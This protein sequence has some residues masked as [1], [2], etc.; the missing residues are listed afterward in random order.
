LSYI[1]TNADATA[2]ANDVV[3]R[4]NATVPSSGAAAAS[5]KLVAIQDALLRS[6]G[7]QAHD[8]QNWTNAS[9]TLQTWSAFGPTFTFNAPIAKTYCVQFRCQ[10]YLSSGTNN[11][12]YARVRN[13]TTGISYDSFPEFWKSPGAAGGAT[14]YVNPFGEVP[15]PMNAG[16]NILTIELL[17]DTGTSW[18]L[19]GLQ[20]VFLIRG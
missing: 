20:R 6:V 5:D 4:L 8:V 3:S 9:V 13:N 18:S 1:P 7:F 14:C 16:N 11:G 17:A 15:I 12:L 10:A 2:V 19:N